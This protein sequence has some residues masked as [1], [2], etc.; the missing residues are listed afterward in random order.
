MYPIRKRKEEKGFWWLRPSAS[1]T[2]QFSRVLNSFHVS[3][4]MRFKLKSI[5]IWLHVPIGFH[6]S[7]SH[8]HVLEC[9]FPEDIVPIRLVVSKQLIC[10]HILS[11]RW[12][13]VTQN[14]SMMNNF[15][16]ELRKFSVLTF[17]CRLMIYCR[18]NFVL[19][20]NEV[21]VATESVLE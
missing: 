2:S 1:N 20:Y 15:E 11:T 13:G 19:A 18:G 8:F 14:S 3:K 12:E 7:G 16:H 10:L 5:T 4:K 6:F 17:F 21:K 9:D